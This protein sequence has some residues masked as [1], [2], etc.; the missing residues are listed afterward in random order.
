MKSILVT[1]GAGFIGSN[2]V[3]Y[4]AQK[5][6]NYH[7]INLDKLTYAGNLDNLTECADMPNYTFVQG[8]IC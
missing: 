4:F 8:D 5:Y 1:G 6:P 7:V 2:F 3:P